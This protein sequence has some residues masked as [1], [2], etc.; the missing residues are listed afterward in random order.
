MRERLDAEKRKELD[1][2]LAMATLQMNHPG[3]F[4]YVDAYAPNIKPETARSLS[5]ALSGIREKGLESR[6]DKLRTAGFIA[7][8]LH[9]AGINR[10]KELDAFAPLL[11]HMVEK[12]RRPV[13]ATS[14]LLGALGSGCM[15]HEDLTAISPALHRETD[16]T[17]YGPERLINLIRTGLESGALV[18]KHLV[19]SA[20]HILDA[21][22]MQGA[23]MFSADLS[24]ALR[25]KR[26]NHR[27]LPKVIA[28]FKAMNKRGDNRLRSA[29]GLFFT[30][31]G[32]YHLGPRQSVKL[33]EGMAQAFRGYPS[34]HNEAFYL[35]RPIESGVNSGNIKQHQ[36]L[37]LIKGMQKHI[38]AAEKAGCARDLH[39]IM[40]SAFWNKAV[41]A[42]NAERTAA[43]L[44]SLFKAQ[45]AVNGGNMGEKDAKQKR[46]GIAKAVQDG[47]E[48]GLT[49]EHL[50][51]LLPP[52]KK[53]THKAAYQIIT[54]A[55]SAA[56]RYKITPAQMRELRPYMG[57][58]RV[59]ADMLADTAAFVVRYKG[60]G[61]VKKR[62]LSFMARSYRDHQSYVGAQ[63]GEL[64]AQ[65]A[66]PRDLPDPAA[67]SKV[68][69]YLEALMGEGRLPFTLA[70]VL[71]SSVG[72]KPKGKRVL[73]PK[74][75]A[76]LDESVLKEDSLVRYSPALI[77]DPLVA[78]LR[79]K[80]IP[81]ERMREAAARIKGCID[82][83]PWG[84]HFHTK[85]Q[86][87]SAAFESRAARYDN[88]DHTLP[89]ILDSVKAIRSI[90]DDA[91]AKVMFSPIF[92]ELRT[93]R[94]DVDGVHSESNRLVSAID[95]MSGVLGRKLPTDLVV[96]GF[97]GPFDYKNF[98]DFVDLALE[99]RSH[100]PVALMQQAIGAHNLGVP[101]NR[102]IGY[103]EEFLRREHFPAAKSILYYHTK[104]KAKTR[105]EKR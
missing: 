81:R 103:Q 84:E 24:A 102:I 98:P 68:F 99:H 14:S 40:T 27:T 46:A 20:D 63:T 93:G 39:N 82:T 10:S 34:R 58:G 35:T 87:L 45:H 18:K 104:F 72:S 13:L 29:L 73:I 28:P 62:M 31:Q 19:A 91:A 15:N 60:P 64:S 50:H 17:P 88:L 101:K 96:N 52:L 41:T 42:E 3:V 16:R 54:A 76:L 26:I 74:D 5:K 78:G 67:L 4:R 75:L 79:S 49:P 44:V 92:E 51:A 80:A 25:E 89:L 9:H 95:R 47:F 6:D 38:R 105:K 90:G 57:S 86:L 55:T 48:N 43:D 85:S 70:Q 23:G 37:P 71:F 94:I 30:A 97:K 1:H 61:K 33:A 66:H 11:A 2:T 22:A 7:G 53:A 21:T 56:R 8:Y 83:P 36:L 77:L 59:A 32:K 100:S 69:P 65:I 12:G